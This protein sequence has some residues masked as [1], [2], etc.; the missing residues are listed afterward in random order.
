MEHSG[1]GVDEINLFL[2]IVVWDD[3][4]VITVELQQDLVG[5]GILRPDGSCV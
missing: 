5:W 3:R 1:V 4:S 2:A